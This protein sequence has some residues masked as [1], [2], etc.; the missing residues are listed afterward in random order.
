[1]IRHTGRFVLL[2]GALLVRLFL[3]AS[4]S[5]ASPIE[6]VTDL[7][8]GL[9]LIK[10]DNAGN[11]IVVASDGRTAYPFAEAV[12][13]NSSLPHYI[14]PVPNAAPTWDPMTNGNP[15]NAYSNWENV[16][17]AQDG[18][19]V[20]T[21][22]VGVAA[23]SADAF[24]GVYA[25]TLGLDGNYQPLKLLWSSPTNHEL[26]NAPTAAVIAAGGDGLLLGRGTDPTGSK[27]TYFVYDLKTNTSTDL[28]RFMPPN[29][30]IDKAI[31]I[32]SQGR[33][34]LSASSTQTGGVDHAYLLSPMITDP[35]TVPEPSSIAIAG[36]LLGLA[37]LRYRR[38]RT[39]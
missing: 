19:F 13:S 32:D 38:L 26:F 15:R 10:L 23:H 3:P 4:P 25:A 34:L 37:L 33:V 20:G 7:G 2:A 35:L 39:L 24:S 22:V 16:V 14:P 8:A 36:I 29:S 9:P 11:R 21:N 27:Q 18:T 5:H 28:A 12:S 31:A 6:T 30:T 1:M 17:H